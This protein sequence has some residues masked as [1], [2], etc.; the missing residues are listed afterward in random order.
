MHVD[1]SSS[2]YAKLCT[3]DLAKAR[4][5]GGFWAERQRVNLASSLV[6]AFGRLESSGNFNNLRLAQGK[7]EGEYREPLFM[8]S[9]IYKWL[10][11]VGYALSR[12]Q[13]T[14]LRE[15][16]DFAIQILAQTQQNDGYLNSYYQFLHPDRIWHELAQGH[17]LYCAGHLFEAAVAFK[18]G[19][20][21]DSLLDIAV[22]FAD[23]IDREFGP[24]GRNGP[25]GHPEIELAL[26]EL[27]RETGEPRYLELSEFFLDQRGRGT[28]IGYKRFPDYYYQDRV[29]V[30]NSSV[31]EGH[32]VRQLYLTAGM[33]DLYLEK[34][35]QRLWQALNRLWQDLVTRKLHITGGVGARH[36]GEAFGKA[37]E[38]PNDTT[39]CET[40]A[41]IAN[42]MWNWRMLLATRESRYADLMER[43][44][45]N[46]V[47]AGVS[48]DGTRYFYENPLSSPG[49]LER[50]TWY[51]CACCPPNLMRLV[52]LI[53]HHSATFDGNGIQIHQFVDGDFQFDGEF[54]SCVLRIETE[55]PHQGDMDIIFAEVPSQPIS[56]A[57]RVPSWAK[58]SMQVLLS[59]SEVGTRDEE[60]GYHTVSHTWMPGD[61]VAV[62]MDLRPRL[63]VANPRVDATR[64]ALAIERGPLVYCL[65]EVDNNSPEKLAD[66]RINPLAQLTEKFEADLLWGV[67]MIAAQGWETHANDWDE[68]LYQSY[69]APSNGQEVSLAAAPY[70]TWANRGAGAMQVWIPLGL[71]GQEN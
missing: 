44:L 13:N 14:D 37:Y 54:G 22:K 19:T 46:C 41:A 33:T 36:F 11:A 27:A 51:G 52:E 31:L 17:E 5:Q 69:P 70:Y 62:S 3:L 18:R 16:A 60:K 50:P 67:V 29:P 64:G 21:E 15:K 30:R 6:H 20:G 40:C 28:L 2:P 34:G 56:L 8:D 63:T 7:G 35:D 61:R 53:A 68:F 4:A 45:Y 24:E 39:Y 58:E 23:L 12:S 38:L 1:S 42:V 49:G 71:Q 57:I 25:P 65:E 26:V 66:L 48:L 47:L 55:Y 59:G 9:D 43:S 32:A 10:E